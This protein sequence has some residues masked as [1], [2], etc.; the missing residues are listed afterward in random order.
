[1][2]KFFVTN[3]KGVDFVVNVIAGWN[4][5]E[6][7]V[8]CNHRRGIGVKFKYN[9]SNA[10]AHVKQIDFP[11]YSVLSFVVKNQY[12]TGPKHAAQ[13]CVDHIDEIRKFINIELPSRCVTKELL[14][15]SKYF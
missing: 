1:M 11:D 7:R 15:V 4:I 2:E 8:L 9:N 6:V 12:F 14:T 5:A 3:L 10:F 13:Y